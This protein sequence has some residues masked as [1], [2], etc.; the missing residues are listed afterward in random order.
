MRRFGF[1]L[2][3]LPLALLLVACPRTVSLTLAPPTATVTA[4][5][6]AL[7]FT[8]T[9]T[10]SSATIAWALSGPG[11]LSDASGP[12]TDYTPPASVDSQTTATITATAGNVSQS[13]T[14]TITP[15]E[16]GPSLSVDPPSATVVAGGEA[17]TFTATLA[18]ASDTVTWSLAGEG[19][20][21]DASGATTSYTP[22]ASV[23]AEAT[24]TLTATAG[25]LSRAATI[26]IQPAPTINVSGKVLDLQG[27]GLSGAQVLIVDAAGPKTAVMS[28][29]D[30]SFTVNGVQTPYS[31]SASGP[32]GS[33]LTPQTWAGVTRPNPQ[34][35]LGIATTGSSPDFCSAGNGRISGTITPAVEAGHTATV[36]YLSSQLSSQGLEYAS[37]NLTAGATNYDL[38]AYFDTVACRTSASGKLIYLE[39]DG[40]GRYV[41]SATADSVYVVKDNTVTTTQNL[42][43]GPVTTDTLSGSV[44]FPPG[45]S[46]ATV[47]A[48][49]KVGDAYATLPEVTVSAGSPGFSLEVPVLAGAQYRVVAL[50]QIATSS[51]QWVWSDV[52]SPGQAGISLALSGISDQQGPSGATDDAT[53]T[54][55]YTPVEGTTVYTVVLLSGTDYI[56]LGTSG[57]TSLALP[58]L[59]PPAQL[60]GGSSYQWAITGMTVRNADSV[61]DLLDGRLA[62]RSYTAGLGISLP[63][64]IRSGHINASFANFNIP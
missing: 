37:A 4:G 56:W 42:T 19:S 23:A 45:L 5:G 36:Y 31:I 1:L 53:P 16:A 61:D 40:A 48:V 10:G 13:A 62:G 11:E 15:G 26:T 57:E 20:L 47:A 64:E 54:F 33:G 60:L 49:L 43:P 41:R 34:A 6:D 17:V 59:P 30:G 25:A 32:S 7:T 51:A 50:K 24:A 14:V 18:G 27:A 21:S 28:G 44:A 29:A 63:D 55:R 38:F 9:L 22:P 39:R 52:V 35:V 8:A 3:T 2:L 46:D 58:T 12:T